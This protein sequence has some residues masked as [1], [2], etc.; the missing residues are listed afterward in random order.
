[1]DTILEVIKRL[2]LID[3]MSLEQHHGFEPR[4][5]LELFR[6]IDGMNLISQ[7][8]FELGLNNLFIIEKTALPARGKRK[9]S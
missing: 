5:V 2:K 7:K 3:G 6:G 1:M 8:R 4:Q 9:L